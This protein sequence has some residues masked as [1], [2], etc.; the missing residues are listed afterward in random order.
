[1]IQDFR[2]AFRQ[3]WKAPGFTIAA[4][5]VLALGIGVN[6]AIFSLVNTMLFKPP[7]YKK[8]S[9]VVQLFWIFFALPLLTGVHLVPLWAG[10]IV[11]GLN[12]GAYGAEIVRGAVQSVPRAQYEGA[13]ALSF[14]PAQRMWRVILPQA[15]IEMLPPFNNL[16]I[17]LLK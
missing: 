1:M 6:T 16:F 10:I 17:Q 11:T 3:L 7:A 4:V 8:P 13:T 15:F 14:T 5:T 9:E 12:G 2:F